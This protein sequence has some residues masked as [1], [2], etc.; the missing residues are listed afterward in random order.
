LVVSL[1]CLFVFFL[2]EIRT[3]IN[4]LPSVPGTVNTKTKK[5]KKKKKRKKKKKKQGEK[6]E[7]KKAH[8]RP[9]DCA[10]ELTVIPCLFHYGKN[11]AAATNTATANEIAP[12]RTHRQEK[13]VR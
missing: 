7:R 13:R 4:E 11:N 12:G 9:P 2:F 3:W 5:T 6:K 8:C 10:Q 1:F